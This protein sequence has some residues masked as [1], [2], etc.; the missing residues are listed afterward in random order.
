M[1]PSGID[2][3][4]QELTVNCYCNTLITYYVPVAGHALARH[5]AVTLDEAGRDALLARLRRR[6][7]ANQVTHL[8]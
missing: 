8:V 6:R 2:K 5:D 3:V 7:V 1:T 4:S